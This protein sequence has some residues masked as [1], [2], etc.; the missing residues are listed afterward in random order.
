MA[1]MKKKMWDKI[2]QELNHFTEKYLRQATYME[3]RGYLPQTAHVTNRNT[4]NSNVETDIQ[5]EDT[6]TES[7]NI[8]VAEAIDNSNNTET[9]PLE[10]T[11][12]V[13]LTD[14]DKELLQTLQQRFFEN[15]EKYKLF[16]NREQ[17]TYVN[18]KPSDGELKVID[19]IIK[20][21]FDNLKYV[22]DVTFDDIN[23][24]I[25][26]AAV[27]IKEYLKDVK[28]A[29]V[30]KEEPA[31]PKWILNLDNKI[32]R[33]R[34]DISHT[35]LILSCSVNNNYTEHQRRIRERL[36]YKFGNVK[37]DTLVYRVKLLTQELKTT[38]SKVSYHRKKIQQDRIN[39]LLAKKPTLVHRSFWGG[40]VEIN[41]PPSMDEVEKFWNDIWRKK[42]T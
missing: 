32:K 42:V 41:K 10:Q 2:H 16:D 7:N 21:Y 25:Y 17:L 11:C 26:S 1:R 29:K 34:R 31:E 39:R 4:E 40:T 13:T 22:R 12:H 35:Q 3:E 8:E 19:A 5:T 20:T 36:R 6:S 33:L 23:T 37:R 18:K 15:I 38:S 27:T 24:V 28:Y 30:R 14:A 9:P